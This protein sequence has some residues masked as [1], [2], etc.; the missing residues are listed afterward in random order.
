M[1]SN[2]SDANCSFSAQQEHVNAHIIPFMSY[3]NICVLK[4]GSLSRLC[5]TTVREILSLLDNKKDGENEKS[6]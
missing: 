6:S 4:N 3:I 1:F 5:V 2:N